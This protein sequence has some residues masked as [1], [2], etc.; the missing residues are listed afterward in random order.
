ME[1]LCYK[2][3]VDSGTSFVWCCMCV[4][5]DMQTVVCVGQMSWVINIF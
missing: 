5:L 4:C 2:P 1:L 3:V